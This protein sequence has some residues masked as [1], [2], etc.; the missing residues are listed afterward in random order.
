MESGQ[1][2]L[3]AP[4]SMRETYL[5]QLQS[6][7]SGIEKACGDV[8]ADYKLFDTQTPL[9]IALSEYLYKRSQLG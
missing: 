6:F 3:V 5:K 1:S 8:R 9:E 4:Q 7:L 2:T